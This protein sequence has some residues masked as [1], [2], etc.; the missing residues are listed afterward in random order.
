VIPLIDTLI[1]HTDIIWIYG[2][3]IEE[4]SEPSWQNVQDILDGHA[5]NLKDKI[6]TVVFSSDHP[7]WIE[8]RQN[9]LDTKGSATK[10][11]HP[12]LGLTHTC[13]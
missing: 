3:S 6:D 13:Y 2:L 8:L 11:K 9:L 7:Y 12:Y 10:L 1:P 5:P 4:R